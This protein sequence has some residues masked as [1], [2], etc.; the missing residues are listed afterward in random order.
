MTKFL[1]YFLV[2]SWLCLAA[3]AS[4]REFMERGM[5][6]ERQK[7]QPEAAAYY[8][9]VLETEKL[10]SHTR[11]WMLNKVAIFRWADQREAAVQCLRQASLCSADAT[12][13]YRTKVFLGA[14]YEKYDR[15]RS[16]NYYLSMQ[17]EKQ[18]HP[19]LRYQGYFNAAS[20]YERLGD[21]AE[22][23]KCYRKAVEAGK[24]VPYKYNYTPAE[25]AVARLEK[26]R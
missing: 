1:S 10:A 20:C 4:D 2:L 19:G 16:V 14:Y 26:L 25:K 21:P 15:F 24:S 22:A 6:L 8:L 13:T 3:C 11:R 9:K 7:K 17:Q 12:E 23:L 18:I 5:A